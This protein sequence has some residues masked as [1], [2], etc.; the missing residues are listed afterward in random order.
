MGD[1]PRVKVAVIIVI[2]GISVSFLGE[3][4]WGVRVVFIKIVK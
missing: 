1:L 4:V 2:W 3:F